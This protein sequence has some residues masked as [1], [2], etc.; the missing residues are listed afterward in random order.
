AM[1]EAV[2]YQVKHWRA[3]HLAGTV[4]ADPNGPAYENGLEDGDVLVSNHPQLA[5]GSH[6]PDITVITPIFSGGK[7]VFFV[8]SR[9][10]HADI[11]GI[12]PGSMPPLSK[13]LREEGAAIVAFKLVQ[14][15]CF[16]QEGISQLLL[17]P[18][19]WEGN[20]GTRNLSD[21]ISDL[22]AQ[23]AANNR[24]K[25][26]VDELVHEYGLG[27]VQ[28]Y[29]EFIQSAAETAVRRMLRDF[30]ES[31]G[32]DAANGA[33][34]AEDFLDDGTPIK[35]KVSINREDGSAVFDFAGTGHEMYGNLN[36]FE[37][38]AASQG[39][40]NNL[41]FGDGSMGYYETIAG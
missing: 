26:L 36:A 16:Q 29:M 32:L 35:L 1:S 23:V 18:G 6:L 24:G 3:A 12:A 38:C 21:N 10:H 34:T 17:A 7:I 33:V 5:G 40:M 15:G 11:G 31:R 39:C 8:A 20:F 2:R 27:V 4:C 14:R 19:E 37:A 25:A 9:G 30:S 41:T 28:A 22:Q 13:T